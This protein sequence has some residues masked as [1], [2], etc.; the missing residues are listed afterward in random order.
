MLNP[1]SLE[2]SGE[3]SPNCFI[4]ENRQLLLQRLWHNSSESQTRW[5]LGASGFHIYC[6]IHSCFLKVLPLQESYIQSPEEHT[7]GANQPGGDWWKL[8]AITK[9]LL[10]AGG[11]RLCVN[12][13]NFMNVKLSRCETVCISYNCQEIFTYCTVGE[14]SS[15]RFLML[16]TK[17]ITNFYSDFNCT[18]GQWS[19]P[20]H[21]SL[22]AVWIRPCLD[23]LLPEPA[24]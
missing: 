15:E 13:E 18:F 12:F 4:P 19:L 11:L 6:T 5:L 16:N 10:I 21:I 22:P 17:E 8:W 24:C 7:D 14:G 9:E 2:E 3:T 20:Y 23:W 1:E